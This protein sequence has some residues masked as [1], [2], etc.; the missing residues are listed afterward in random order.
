[1]TNPHLTAIAVGIGSFAAG[2]AVGYK[3]AEKRLATEF[4]ERLER[5]TAEMKTFYTSIERK[6]FATPQEAVE[7]LMPK[8][9][10]EV[11]SAYGP[12][13]TEMRVPIAYDKIKPVKT[14]SAK[15]SVTITNIT[16]TST[17]EI[18]VEAIVEKSVFAKA[19]LRDVSKPYIISQEEFMENAPDYIQNTVTYYRGDN[20]LADERDD[21]IEEIE[22]VVGLDC[23][24]S[25]GKDSSDDRAVHVRNEVLQLD[26]EVLLHEGSYA[27]EV[28]GV[29]PIQ[30]ARR[31]SGR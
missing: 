30:P 27:T 9:A 14:D 4:E 13:E 11:L 23:L 31:P 22:K 16:Q 24:V 19:E 18:E 17:D 3:V 25:F 5:E 2:A 28:L 7:E 8:E 12:G 1:M 6:K 15:P 26:F 21:P 29:D 20:V 10:S